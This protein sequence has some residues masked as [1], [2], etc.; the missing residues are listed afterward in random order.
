M[1]VKHCCYSV[2]MR[3]R[4]GGSAGSAAARAGRALVQGAYLLRLLRGNAVRTRA[5]G[6]QM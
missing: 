3:R 1:Y 5:P 2:A 6:T 4:R